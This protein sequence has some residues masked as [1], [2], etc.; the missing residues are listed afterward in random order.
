MRRE[1]NPREE[2]GEMEKKTEGRKKG[3][4]RLVW[5]RIPRP[6]CW[7]SCCR[8][9]FDLRLIGRAKMRKKKHRMQ[10]R[11]DHP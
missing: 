3:V 6:G 8:L 9:R 7:R 5:D 2:Q 10:R 11:V 1:K 4:V